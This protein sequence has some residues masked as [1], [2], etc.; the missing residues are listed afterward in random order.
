MLLLRLCQYYTLYSIRSSSE[1]RGNW[2]DTTKTAPQQCFGN[3]PISEACCMATCPADRCPFQELMDRGYATP[4]SS[5]ARSPDHRSISMGFSADLPIARQRRLPWRSVH[6]ATTSDGNPR[7]T[8]CTSIAMAER[9][10]GTGYRLESARV[11][12]YIIVWNASHLECVLNAY[13]EYY[14]T[15]RTHLGLGKDTPTRRSVERCGRIIATDILGGLHHQYARIWFLEGTPTIFVS[16]RFFERCE[17]N[18]PP[19]TSS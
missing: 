10:R 18:R 19:C 13:M 16:R 6:T 14:N 4:N 7:S 8:S 11:L 1:V 12:D 2:S 15:T 9:I 5:V 3:S 17:A